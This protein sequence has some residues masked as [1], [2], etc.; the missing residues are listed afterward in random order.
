MVA[1]VVIDAR[2]ALYNS[3]IINTVLVVIVLVVV[4]GIMHLPRRRG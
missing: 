4:D 3:V 2:L 1:F